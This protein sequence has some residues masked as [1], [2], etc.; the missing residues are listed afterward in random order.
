MFPSDGFERAKLVSTCATAVDLFGSKTSVAV[1]SEPTDVRS[2]NA[3]VG[4]LHC[5]KLEN[6]ADWEVGG[7]NST[8][9]IGLE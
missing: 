6:A 3:G 2:S 8:R 1:G 7:R 9:W 5:S 4:K